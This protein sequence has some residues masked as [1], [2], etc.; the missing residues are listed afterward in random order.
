MVFIELKNRY[1]NIYY[2]QK[3]DFFIPEKN[4]I[5]LVLPFINKDSV[6]AILEQTLHTDYNTIKIITMGY[7]DTFV[8]NN[9]KVATLPYWRWILEYEDRFNN[10]VCRR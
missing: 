3:I 4:M 8:Y 6:V 2:D 10:F 5:I 1:K 9:T 7:E